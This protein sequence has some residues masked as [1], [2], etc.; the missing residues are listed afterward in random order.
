MILYFNNKKILFIHIPKTGGT[1]IERYF[2]E[3]MKI[4]HFKYPTF[5]QEYLWGLGENKLQYQHLTMKQI[6]NDL[7]LYKLDDFD[8]IF[9]VVRDPIKRFISE[10]NWRPQRYH[11]PQN[12]IDKIHDKSKRKN[13]HFFSQYDFIKGYE[14]KLKIYKFED[15][16]NNIVNDVIEVNKFNINMPNLKYIKKSKILINDLSKKYKDEILKVF[17]KDFLIF[18]Y[19]TNF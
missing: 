7:K 6:F 9:T 14:N 10:C 19:D 4:N 2:C 16:I 5:Y 8:F 15:G 1:T 12:L 3:L 13:S 18:K 17:L 11:N